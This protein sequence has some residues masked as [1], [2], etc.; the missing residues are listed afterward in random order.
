MSCERADQAFMG[1]DSETLYQVGRRFLRGD[2]LEQ[3]LERARLLL[4]KAAACGHPMAMKL[5][6]ELEAQSPAEACG[7]T[8]DDDVLTLLGEIK[9]LEQTIADSL[10]LVRQK[11]QQLEDLLNRRS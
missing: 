8:S 10:L 11:Q 5:M 7:A 4:G 3:N 9:A 2:G 1:E 6:E